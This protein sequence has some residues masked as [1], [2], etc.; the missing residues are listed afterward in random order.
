MKRLAGSVEE[1]KTRAI[2]A[3]PGV[4][5]VE[6]LLAAFVANGYTSGD[7]PLTDRAWVA[8][9]AATAITCAFTEVV[10]MWRVYVE[11]SARL[12]LLLE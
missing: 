1:D 10:E 12:A 3:V 8:C 4:L 7:Q 2:V 5:V 6:T 9:V 11:V